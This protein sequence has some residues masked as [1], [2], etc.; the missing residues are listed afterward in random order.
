MPACERREVSIRTYRVTTTHDEQG[1]A[2]GR[3]RR[4]YWALYLL[5]SHSYVRSS[6]LNVDIQF[7][8]FDG[9]LSGSYVVL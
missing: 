5:D 3:S 1:P 4:Q 2:R 8:E 9:P 6:G 7:S